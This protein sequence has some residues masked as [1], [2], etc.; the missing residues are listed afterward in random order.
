[1][2]PDNPAAVWAKLANEFEVETVPGDHLGIMTTHFESLASVLSRFVREPA[3]S[4]SC[5]PAGSRYRGG[6]YRMQVRPEFPANPPF[7][8]AAFD[9]NSG[10]VPSPVPAIPS[11]FTANGCTN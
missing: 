11:S 2:F 7:S 9:V 8:Y 10:Q 5:R 6:S 1:M 4:V 3:L